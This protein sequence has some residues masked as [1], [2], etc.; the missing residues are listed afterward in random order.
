MDKLSDI[1]ISPP[2]SVGA[3]RIA[4][5]SNAEGKRLSWS[6][7]FLRI[8]WEPST[9]DTSG[10]GRL[11]LALQPDEE[12]MNWY[13]KLD[14]TFLKL[15]SENSV[16]LFGKP[17]TVEQVALL[18]TSPLRRSTRGTHVRCKLVP[19]GQKY[20]TRVWTEDKTPAL[21]PTGLWVGHEARAQIVL[22]SLWVA[23]GRFGLTLTCSDLVLRPIADEDSEAVCPFE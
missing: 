9:V 22:S 7:S 8:V 14:S 13:D 23:G 3:T 21:W 15:A 12:T 11:T 17:L 6:T 4:T 2:V 20:S 18:Y 19:P 16:A 1:Q 5:V 10:T